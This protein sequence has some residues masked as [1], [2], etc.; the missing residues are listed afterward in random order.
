MADYFEEARQVDL[1]VARTEPNDT[2]TL[3]ATLEATFTEGFTLMAY[4]P[5]VSLATITIGAGRTMFGTPPKLIS[6]TVTPIFKGTSH[7]VHATSGWAFYPTP[8]TFRVEN[9]E[10]LS[11][12]LPHVNAEGWRDTSGNEFPALLE[13]GERDKGWAYHAKF[14]VVGGS[15][16]DA[17]PHRYE[18]VF[19]PLVGQNEPIDLDLIPDGQIGEPVSAPA[20][21]VTDFMGLSGSITK[22]DLVAAG[23]GVPSDSA[24]AALLGDETSAAGATLETEI[25][26]R[27]DPLG[28]ELVDLSNAIRSNFV[29]NVVVAPVGAPQPALEEGWVLMRYLL[30]GKLYYT[31]FSSTAVGAVPADWTARWKTFD[32]G[33]SVKADAAAAGGKVLSLASATAERFAAS[34]NPLD[35]DTDRGNVEVLFRSKII[36]AASSLPTAIARAS[37]ATLTETAYR[38]GGRGMANRTV[39]KYVGGAYTDLGSDTFTMAADTWYLTRFRVNGSTIQVRVW[40]DGASEPSTWLTATDTSIAAPGWVGLALTSNAGERHIDWVAAATGGRTAVKQ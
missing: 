30:S 28:A 3:A 32:V 38:G 40:A 23:L 37:G 13:S 39:S 15:G 11:F 7:V 35:S 19:Q 29:T 8:Q 34:W 14:T 4:P 9:G 24:I 17:V 6:A 10:E 18:K 27:L 26:N 5:G 16:Q 22:E 33:W 31:D 12:E 21:T 20:A 2:T 25:N 1:T 36:G